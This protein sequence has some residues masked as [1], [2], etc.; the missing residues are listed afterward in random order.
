MLAP[1]VQVHDA[2]ML[3][4]LVDVF[5]DTGAIIGFG[6]AYA[7]F[8]VLNYLVELGTED[9]LVAY[10]GEVFPALEV[11]ALGLEFYAAKAET[12]VRVTG[13]ADFP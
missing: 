8:D 11:D 4:K 1:E 7:A 5:I 6:H 10:F 3:E 2:A 9:G 12:S 13:A